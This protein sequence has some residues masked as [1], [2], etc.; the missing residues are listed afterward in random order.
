MDA[1]PKSSRLPP[2]SPLY[3]AICDG[4]TSEVEKLLAGADVNA[5]VFNGQSPLYVACQRQHL[6]LVRLLLSVG[7]NPN[8]ARPDKEAPLHVAC[9]EGSSGAVDLLLKAGADI[10][11]KR[12]NGQTAR[13]PRCGRPAAGGQAAKAAVPLGRCSTWQPRCAFGLLCRQCPAPAPRLTD[14][15]RGHCAGGA[16]GPCGIAAV[17]GLRPDAGGC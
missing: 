9:Q 2:A 14:H 13:G 11:A 12:A 15:A 8:G 10:T 3:Y 1:S 6:H 17:A 7:A 5:P 4:R 16:L